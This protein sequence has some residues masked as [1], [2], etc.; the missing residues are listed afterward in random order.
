[1][2]VTASDKDH[3]TDKKNQLASIATGKRIFPRVLKND[4][5]KA[6]MSD[7]ILKR[8]SAIYLYTHCQQYGQRISRVQLLLPP[9]PKFLRSDMVV[10]RY[11]VALLFA[12]IFPLCLGSTLTEEIRQAHVLLK[13]T[14]KG[15][16][17]TLIW[18]DSEYKNVNLDG[19]IG[20][21]IVEGE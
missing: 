12:A 19:I 9:F 6:D 7:Q 17:D 15:L 14:L 2:I 10:C 8:E 13:E 18:F 4:I 11:G 16:K 1:M 20:T 3:V 5:N 21:R